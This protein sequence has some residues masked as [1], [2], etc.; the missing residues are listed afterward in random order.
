MQKKYKL[1][2]IGLFI[3]LFSWSQ[4]GELVGKVI[5][6]DSNETL[7]FANVIVKGTDKGVTSDFEGNYEFKLAP[8]MYS[9]SFSFLGFETKN[10][11][12]VLI[13]EGEST[14]LDVIL[15]P[16]GISFDT[17]VITA[18]KAR[19]T[20]A[21]M[22]NVQKKSVNL[23]DGISAQAFQK[24]SVS[25]VA[26]AVKN[27][28]G[29]SVQGS[30]YVY[31]RGL[32][33]RYTKSILNGVD[34]PGLDPD[35]NT[36][37]LD[38]FPTNIIDNIQ[39]LKSSTANY[40]SDFT[41]GMVNI[42]TKDLP[43][44]KTSSLSFG[45]SFNPEMH[46][47]RNYLKQKSSSSDFIGFDNG[48]R[49]LPISRNQV[50]PGA[51][52]KNPAL[53]AITKTF[54]PSLKAQKGT[55]GMDFNMAFTT[56]NNYD[57]GEGN[58]L[59][60]LASI[61][62]KNKTSFYKNYEQGFYRKFADK[63]VNKLDFS[64]N[65]IGD[66]G[67][68][69]VLVSG[70]AGVT[71]KTEK[72]KYRL[73]LLHIQNGESTA[74]N[75]KQIK[76]FSDA[77]TIFKDNLQYT[78]RSIS[79][80]L[81][82]GKHSNE[83]ASF[84][85]DWKLSPTYSFIQDKDVR[86][87]PFQ[88]DEI[89]NVYSIRPS[90]AGSPRRIW[91]TLVELN[92][93][94]NV[95]FT[96]KHSLFSNDAKF[97]FGSSYI[98]KH[99]NFSIDDYFLLLRGSAGESLNGNADSLL[100]NENIYNATTGNG[101]Y[102]K[103]NYEPSNTYESYNNNFAGYLSE[104]FTLFEKLKAIV[105]VRVEKFQQFYTGQNNSGSIIYNNVKTIDK[106]DLFPSSNFIYNL[107]DDV[108]LR[109]S[110]A[111]TVARPSFKEA[112]IT[113]IFDPLTNL[114]FNG[115]I[116]LQ[117]SYINNFDIRFEKFGK[118]A[119]LIAVSAFYKKFNN[120]IELAFFS[121]SAP[122]NLQPRNIG[123]ANVYGVEIDIRKNLSFIGENLENFNINFNT[124]LIKSR[125]EMDRSPNGEYES[126]LLNLRDGETLSGKRDLQGQSP[127][128]INAG[129]SYNNKDKG[130]QAGLFYN[131]QGKSLE[132]VGIGAIPDVYTVPFNSVN[133]TF[134]KAFGDDQKSIVS[135]KI[136]NLLNNDRE[137]HFQ[138][139]KAQDQIFSKRHIGQSFSV[140]YS[141]KF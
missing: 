138:S 127:Y 35:R 51:F 62:Y 24:L 134:S 75:F 67:V 119:Q 38:I 76:N 28:S 84:I 114:T 133:I 49:D 74:G 99:R 103:G 23:M 5:D 10:I 139:Y 52:S 96:L 77:V 19:N 66:L 116:D 41:G 1:L 78:Q 82:S 25:N 14:N 6:G 56:G 118:K 50:I 4:T 20:E 125:Q 34:I 40:P 122:D 135:I 124:S 101:T 59:G 8:G 109:V 131:V 90:S 126:K 108:N 26:S 3:S 22:L 80:G 88:F 27:V 32:G 58:K 102:T 61:S 39:I 29:V 97:L 136:D 86:V 44:K 73:N 85:V 18:R 69:E 48:F 42:V 70:L 21:S 65:Q 15:N 137:S 94:A 128:L 2:A 83:D 95:D 60:Y 100:S 117:P 121:A 9:I 63:S 79:N 17:V 11:T 113:Q 33:D 104:S 105:G 93:V 98:Y 81:L 106:L 30:K 37:Q 111:R 55:S 57:V 54:N 53:T 132:V 72:S 47:N 71:F 141:V 87:T 112:S 31:V 46:F 12:E 13:K 36:V 43:S 89:T 129:M 92:T 68:N 91:R 107:N 115:N 130:L 123:S 45:G 110:Y 64:E 140:S 7:A 120:P 16:A